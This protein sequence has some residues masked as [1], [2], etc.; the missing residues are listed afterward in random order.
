MS[1]PADTL[2]GV[3]L[4]LFLFGFLFSV[5]SFVLGAAA[6]G[7]VHLPGSHHAGHIGAA[8]HAPTGHAP[9]GGG[10]LPGG[11][12]AE[13]GFAV[14]APLNGSTAVIFL[15]WFGATGY[16]LRHYYGTAPATSFLVAVLC[17]LLGATIVYL[18]LGRVLWRAQ[19]ELYAADYY[20]EG[21]VGRVTSPIR[22]SGTGEIVYTLDRKQQVSGA[23]SV[24]GAALP[25]G[26]EVE[27]VRYERGLAY[28]R[29]WDGGALMD[30][31]FQ[32]RPVEREE[33]VE[34]LS[35]LPPDRLERGR[36]REDTEPR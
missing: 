28:V 10:T 12:A 25:L 7:H 21:V 8:P 20:V 5:A 30:E 6:H 9:A 11:Q 23:R 26:A 4:F 14:P 24:D 19:T 3:Y 32:G 27:I 31:P 29:P 16:V 18:F 34:P 13:S 15:T 36:R 22:A 2:A 33:L 17:G 35:L 1:W